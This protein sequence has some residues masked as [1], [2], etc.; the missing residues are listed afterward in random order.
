MKNIIFVLFVSILIFVSCNND[1]KLEIKTSKGRINLLLPTSVLVSSIFVFDTA[2]VLNWQKEFKE[3]DFINKVFSKVL[4]SEVSV[5]KPFSTDSTKCTKEEIFNGMDVKSEPLNLNE[6]KSIYF[7]EEWAV[8]TAEPF[9][10]EKVVLNWYP[11]RYFK[12]NNEILKKLI[13]KVSAGNPSELLAKNVI[14]EFQLIDTI[15]PSFTE[16]IDALKLVTLLVKKA[17]SGKFKLWDP[18]NTEK[19]LSRKDIDENLG[20][21]VDTTYVEDPQTNETVMKVMKKAIVLEEITSIVFVEDWYYDPKTFAIKK[22]ITGLGPVRS[23]MKY[24]G[25]ITKKVAFMMYFGK[26]K[27]KIF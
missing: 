3:S 10:F 8:D 12:R 21:A 15:Q 17:Y 6:I 5:L 1:R 2:C 20:Q 7:E 16:N 13:F 19:E 24:D 4:S 9:L 18:S 25:E 11:I 22:V 14:T 23:C 26:E 27:T